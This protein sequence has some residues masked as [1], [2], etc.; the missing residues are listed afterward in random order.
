MDLA[1]E[2]ERLWVRGLDFDISHLNFKEKKKLKDLPSN[3]FL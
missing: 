1:V 2:E 3:I